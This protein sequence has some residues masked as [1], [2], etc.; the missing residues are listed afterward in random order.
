MEKYKPTQKEILKLR[1]E[2]VRYA[3]ELMNSL[4]CGMR[5]FAKGSNVESMYMEE[6]IQ[7]LNRQIKRMQDEMKW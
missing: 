4:Q 7:A 1:M 2:Q 6:K 3:K 5:K